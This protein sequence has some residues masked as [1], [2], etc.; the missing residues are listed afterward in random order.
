LSESGVTDIKGVQFKNNAE[1]A[2]CFKGGTHKIADCGVS[3]GKIGFAVHSGSRAD[4]LSS[5]ISRMEI[6]VEVTGKS[7]TSL[8]KT[9]IRACGK[10]VWLQDGSATEVSECVFENSVLLGVYTD[11]SRCLARSAVFAKNNIGLFADR[12]AIVEL[13]NSKFIDNRTGIK[14]DNGSKASVI[15]SVVRGCGWDAIWCGGNAELYLESNTV[16]LN[17]HGIKE[18]GPCVVKASGN[19]FIKN[20]VADHLVWPHS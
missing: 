7:R 16:A 14:A 3:A 15:S 5:D 18:D 2:V 20:S 19:K 10:G 12:G 17:R 9:M 8:A 4:I 11:N 13:H 6:G 1:F